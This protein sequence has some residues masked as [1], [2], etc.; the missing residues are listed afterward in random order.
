MFKY[1]DL[2]KNMVTNWAFV[3]FCFSLLMNQRNMLCQYGFWYIFIVTYLANMT[4]P[5]FFLIW[6]QFFFSWNLWLVWCQLYSLKELMWYVVDIY[7]GESTGCLITLW[8]TIHSMLRLDATP[9]KRCLAFDFK[10]KKFSI[11]QAFSINKKI[12]CPVKAH[13]KN[14][15]FFLLFFYRFCSF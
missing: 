3:T 9:K 12:S 8:H 15:S 13:K 5:F 1:T 10:F 11:K 6:I 4:F 14:W 2:M 7:H